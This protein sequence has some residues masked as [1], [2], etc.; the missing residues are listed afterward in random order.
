MGFLKSFAKTVSD[1]VDVELQILPSLI[2]GLATGG[3]SGLL[4]AGFTSTTQTVLAS[5][6]KES[7]EGVGLTIKQSRAINFVRASQGLPTIDKFGNVTKPGS[8]TDLIVRRDIDAARRAANLVDRPI[9]LGSTLPDFDRAL[10]RDNPFL[11]GTASN[12]SV[13]IPDTT[14]ARPR[15]GG[16]VVLDPSPPPSTPSRP[17]PRSSPGV[18]PFREKAMGSF[19]ETL[20]DRLLAGGEE[21]FKGFVTGG[22]SGGLAAA[23]L[24]AVGG[25]PKGFGGVPPRIARAQAETR[26]QLLTAGLVSPRPTVGDIAPGFRPVG[27]GSLAGPL[28]RVLGKAGVLRPSPITSRVLGLGAGALG[29]GAAF[30]REPTAAER[31]GTIGKPSRFP[32]GIPPAFAGTGFGTSPARPGGVGPEVQTEFPFAPP[33]RGGAGMAGRSNFAKDECDRT[34][35]FFCSPR[36]GEGWVN[37]MDAANLGLKARKPFARFNLQT[38]R[39]ERMPRRRMN[40]A[41]L[42][43]LGRA[44]RRR[45]DFMDLV[46][47]LIRDR[48]KEQAGTRPRLVV[49][50]RRKKKR[51]VA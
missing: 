10:L 14:V 4:L 51:K 8:F 37:V 30:S 31:F 45:R 46:L 28:G 29:A 15:T 42:K 11:S 34:L 23:G 20:G 16:G 22:V 24:A 27:F 32:P 21:I 17:T 40:V 26:N 48:R 47:P 19:F 2:A 39:F 9:V 35:K 1:I 3:V 18:G 33:P 12:L 38:Q 41:N 49:A 5:I 7:F 43:A 44:E 13:R 50:K 25:A 6:N 36:P